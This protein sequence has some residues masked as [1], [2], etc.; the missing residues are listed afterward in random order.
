MAIG[1]LAVA[2]L[3]MGCVSL[4]CTVPK[5]ANPPAR[6]GGADSAAAGQGQKSESAAASVFE[7]RDGSRIVGTPLLASVPLV[8]S[9]GSVAFR[10]AEVTSI[11]AMDSTPGV[12]VEFKNGDVLR[13]SLQVDSLPVQCAAG[14]INIPVSSILRV[15]PLWLGSDVLEGLIARYPLAGNASDVTGH[16]HDGVNRGAVPAPDRFGREAGA[17]AFDGNEAC[18]SLPEGLIDPDCEACTLSLWVLAKPSGVRRM[19]LYIGAATGEIGIGETGGRFSFGADLSTRQ[20]N[21][22]ET[23]VVENVFLHLAGVYIRGKTIRLYLNGE[24]KSEAPVPDLPLVSGL[25]RFTSGIGAYSP[26]YP[27]EGKQRGMSN[28]LGAISDVRIY[29]RALSDRE[30]LSLFHFGD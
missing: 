18:I 12:R 25:A 16:G 22:V 27:A 20:W 29:N 6:Q 19:A 9:Y 1:R 10:P 5:S 7:L 28:W 15:T 21:S 24:K 14:R 13:G 26:G 8:S 3:F 4:S 30:I 2:A 17:C 23:P 11:I